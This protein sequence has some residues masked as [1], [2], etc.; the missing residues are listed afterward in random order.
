MI[1]CCPVSP[2]N[3]SSRFDLGKSSG[4][5]DML[6]EEELNPKNIVLG[7]PIVGTEY[8]TL[9]HECP[10]PDPVSYSYA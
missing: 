9:D 2:I 4:A 1:L 5:Q 7:D 3:A 8:R 6:G 10:C